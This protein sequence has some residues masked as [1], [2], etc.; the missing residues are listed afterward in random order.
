MAARVHARAAL[1]LHG[2]TVH[3]L[4]ASERTA[5][6]IVVGAGRV[7]A[8]GDDA[9]VL[10]GR[11]PGTG[12]V[13]LADRCVVPGFFDA[14]P[15]LDRLGLRSRAGVPIAHCTSVAEIAGGTG[16]SIALTMAPRKGQVGCTAA[17]RHAV[18]APDESG[19]V[20]VAAAGVHGVR[21]RPRSRARLRAQARC[22][23]RTRSLTRA[24]RQPLHSTGWVPARAPATQAANSHPASARR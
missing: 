22:A 19:R 15:H 17:A 11:T 3:A 7:L 6:A 18:G 16:N 8:V 14:H 20:S 24:A 2:G 23:H 5:Q 1:I 12:I 9:A 13:D 10:A 21:S 4:G